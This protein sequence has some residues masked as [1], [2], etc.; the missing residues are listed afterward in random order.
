MT[1]PEDVGRAGAGP[2]VILVS[3][4]S[5]EA[6]ANEQFLELAGRLRERRPGWRVERGFL[7]RALPAFD[8]ALRDAVSAGCSPVAVV[9]CYMFPGGMAGVDIPA[10]AAEVVR[11]N[12]GTVVRCGVPLCEVPRMKEILT[13]Q[14]PLHV[15]NDPHGRVVLM[16]AGGIAVENRDYIE[17]LVSTLRSSSGLSIRYGYLDRGEPLFD[18]VLDEAVKEEPPVRQMAI[19]PCLLF[20]GTYQR[21]LSRILSAYRDSHAGIRFHVGEP[22]GENPWFMDMLEQEAASL[23]EGPARR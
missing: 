2:A 3:H 23:L 5:V 8:G 10:A 13:E 15:L 17:K 16:A 4:G 9:P 6:E 18:W 21:G 20:R 14:V 7:D 22:L 12:P 11:S 1:N 19:L